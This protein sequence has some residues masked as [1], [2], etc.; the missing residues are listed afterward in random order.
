MTYVNPAIPL[1]AA[2]RSTPQGRFRPA[3]P[4]P[5]PQ[6]MTLLQMFRTGAAR[7]L[8][9]AIPE[10]AYN[11]TYRKVSA[12]GFTFHGV[13][14]PQA[15]Q[16]VFLDNAPNYRRPGIVRRML[17]PVLRNSLFMVEGDAWKGQRR[18]MA[19]V[20]AR[21]SVEA[22]MPLFGK[23]ADASVARLPD[24]GVVDVAEEVTR[25]TLEV[26]DAALFGGE[27][28]MP[29][30]ET[31]HYVRDFMA[32][33]TEVRLGMFPGFGWADVLP[34]QVRARRAQRWLRA[35]MEAFVRR[36]SAETDSP[37][38]FVTRLYRTFAAEHPHEEAIR[39][40]LDNAMLFF[41][42][43]HETTANAL[44]W[45]LY[46]LSGDAQAQAWAREEAQQAWAAADGDPA[47]VL[48]RLP[49]LRMAWEET[50][51]LYPPVHRIDR[52]AL[53]DDELRGQPIRKGDIVTIWP[54]VVHRH[55]TLWDEP[56]LF[57]PENFD[58][59]AKEGRNRYQYL[60]FG[61]GPRSCIG[62]GFAQ[63]E[64]LILLSRWVMAFSLRPA[65]GH[66]VRPQGDFSLR[67]N[68]GLPLVVQR[69]PA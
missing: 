65:P 26:I 36:R 2:P 64:A 61:A 52:E 20:F 30:E 17:D 67:P 10:G 66:E 63:A 1:A 57:N 13:S 23:V 34:R 18:M 45:A 27:A 49:Y 28:G 11:D 25:T 46:L 38:D 31:S 47:E 68:G 8:L 56:D 62:M 21:A 3:K 14:D 55:R 58:P 37:T 53:A 69:L 41:V 33:T 4:A 50:L 48:K 15:I 43:G 51:R 22:F 44:A 59:E 32:G 6:D 19:P 35:R 9:E 42:A 16:R 24:E 39:L 7:N 40:T 5:V 54:W 60:P 12:L 29:F